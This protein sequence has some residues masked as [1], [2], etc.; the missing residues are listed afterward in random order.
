M[1]ERTLR[2]IFEN[3]E[4]PAKNVTISIPQS[5]DTKSASA[6]SSAM[7]VIYANKDI[8]SLDIGTPKAAAFVTPLSLTHVNISA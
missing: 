3:A 8:F 4:N 6:I 7:D 2:L 1:A 5:D